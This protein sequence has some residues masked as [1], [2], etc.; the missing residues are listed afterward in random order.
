[1]TST[2]IL[3]DPPSSTASPRLFVGGS[4]SS[5]VRPP[6]SRSSSSSSS[7]TRPLEKSCKLELLDFEHPE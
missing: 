7:L 6:T 5:R 3:E 4:L 2:S 1:M